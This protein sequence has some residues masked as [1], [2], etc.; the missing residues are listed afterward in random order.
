MSV[1]MAYLN[2]GSAITDGVGLWISGARALGFGVVWFRAA[3]A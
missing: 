2:L 1:H 3:K